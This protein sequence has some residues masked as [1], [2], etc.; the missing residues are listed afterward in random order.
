[1][2]D[3]LKAAAERIRRISGGENRVE[4][5][6][7]TEKLSDGKWRNPHNDLL[8][9]VDA[10]LAEHPADDDV[11]I[12]EEWLKSVGFTEEG[13]QRWPVLVSPQSSKNGP[14]CRIYYEPLNGC[15]GWQ[16]GWKDACG[17]IPTLDTR[18]EVRQLCIALRITLKETP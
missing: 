5:Y 2:T 8:E 18:S 9:L 14:I 3:E 1:M 16:I 11:A 10:F 7:T 4:V 12:A 6:G 15:D 17:S 13:K